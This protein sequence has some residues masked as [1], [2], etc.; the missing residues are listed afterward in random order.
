MGKP[1]GKYRVRPTAERFWP[2]VDKSGECWLWMPALRPD[3]Y[4]YFHLDG[5]MQLAHR[6]SYA[7]SVGPIPE[8]LQIDHLCRVR[9]CVRPDHLEAVTQAENIRRGVGGEVNA[10]RQQAKTH[11]PSGHEYDEEN[12]Y[13]HEGTGRPNRA[14]KECRREAVRRYRDRTK[15][16]AKEAA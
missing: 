12:I 14:C 5:R 7:L 2:K 8:G 16:L 13:N 10:A 1:R 11:C 4:G 15:Q 3:G 6:V 9:A